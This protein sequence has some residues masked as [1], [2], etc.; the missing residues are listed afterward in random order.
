[1]ISMKMILTASTSWSWSLIICPSFSSAATENH[2]DV[3]ESLA[4]LRQRRLSSPNAPKYYIS[5]HFLFLPTLDNGNFDWYG[6]VAALWCL[7]C[8]DLSLAFS[9]RCADVYKETSP[10]HIKAFKLSPWAVAM[11]IALLWSLIHVWLI[12]VFFPPLCA[13]PST[14][15]SSWEHF[16]L[17]TNN[18][19]KDECV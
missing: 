1:M 19:K 7:C 2:R 8:Q 18:R 6:E 17:K 4:A 12:V 3:F 13:V 11:E 5:E 9:P 10:A 16:I 15:T 14:K